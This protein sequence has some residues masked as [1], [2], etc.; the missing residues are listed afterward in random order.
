MRKKIKKPADAGTVGRTMERCKTMNPYA[1]YYSKSTE[2][3]A[4]QNLEKAR[5]RDMWIVRK[6]RQYLLSI[7]HPSAAVA[8]W[9][10]YY[11]DCWRTH[12][13]AEATMV[14]K[15]VGGEVVRFNPILGKVF[16]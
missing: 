5:E 2:E 6:D 9:T 13:R 14:A 7:V 8:Q 4:R 1:I 10:Q 12:F 16:D 15:K 3:K 11:F